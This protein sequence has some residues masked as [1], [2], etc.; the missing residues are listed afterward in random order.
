MATSCSESKTKEEN[1]AYDK[2]GC[3]FK[4]TAKGT[5]L[6]E[7]YMVTDAKMLQAHIARDVSKTEMRAHKE[8]L[9][10]QEKEWKKVWDEKVWDE[11]IV[12]SWNQKANE[13]RRTGKYIHLGKLLGMC[14][15]RF[16]ITG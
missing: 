15:K 14:R 10:A 13:A 7:D 4:Q 12:R 5:V 9:L 8:A 1:R 6:D 16:R 11:S 2:A 3:R